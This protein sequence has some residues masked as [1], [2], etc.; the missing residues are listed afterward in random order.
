M[1][2]KHR[3]AFDFL[4]QI[5]KIDAIIE[6]KM[7]EREQW[8][9]L[10]MASTPQTNG[11]RVQ[12]S[13]NQQ[14]MADA[15]VKYVDLEAEIDHYIDELIKVKKDVVSVIEQL[16]PAEY[17][18]L[19]KVY[20]QYFTLNEAAIECDKTYSWVTT[21]HGR[22]LKNVQNI[23]NARKETEKDGKTHR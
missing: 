14:K 2:A 10:A 17:D 3:E 8:R 7:I 5:E 6:N 15:V 23:L 9:R 13:G 16:N 19:H 4:K 18:L 20:V 1:K 11:E 12:S 21:V 22:G